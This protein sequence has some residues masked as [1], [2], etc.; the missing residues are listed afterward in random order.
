MMKR[1][2][3]FGWRLLP[4]LVLALM[5]VSRGVAAQRPVLLVAGYESDNVVQF[6]L[7]S[8]R[9]SEIARLPTNSLPRGI[10]VSDTGEIFLGLQGG[11]QGVAKL[12]P[13]GGQLRH[14]MVSPSFGR[15][16]PGFIIHSQGKLWAAGDTE[17]VVFQIDAQTGEVT[18]PPQMRNCC[19]MVGLAAN[20]DMLYA[21]EYF[22]KSILR[23]RVGG[24]Q[25][26]WERFISKSDHLDRPI[27]MTV[28]HNGNLYV[29]NG[30]AP[31]VVEFDIHSG[32]FVRTLVNIGAG[33]KEGIHAVVYSREADRY[34]LASGS[35]VYEVDPTGKLV[36]TY[37]SPALRKA[38]GIALMPMLPEAKPANPKAAPVV[39]PEAPVT[40]PV[41]T[42]RAAA[43][44][45]QINGAVGERYR[46]LATTDFQTW[47]AIGEIRNSSGLVDFVDPDAAKFTMRF[48]RL[49]LI[50]T[51]R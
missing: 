16:G 18:A 29:A 6:D 33:G 34:Y 40:R 20:G 1:F 14:Q 24:G 22:Q 9:W 45:L 37:N 21:A 19:N 51:G 31:T 38:Y 39:T 15:F 11:D 5:A 13:W 49:E 50:E 7:A 4:V 35:N 8:G 28:G 48:Y 25:A 43:G 27:G 36:A 2:V 30:L 26:E 32:E 12:I 46:V 41:T 44:T 47:T 10:A 17:R 42:L 23:Y 3:S